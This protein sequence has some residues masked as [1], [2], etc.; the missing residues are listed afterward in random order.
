MSALQ[1]KFQYLWEDLQSFPMIFQNEKIC[2][3]TREK[4]VR[5]VF[6][7]CHIF[8]ISRI[9]NKRSSDQISVGNEYDLNLNYKY[10][11]ISVCKGGCQNRKKPCKD[12]LFR[13]IW[14]YQWGLTFLSREK[15]VC[16]Y[17]VFWTSLPSLINPIES[18][19]LRV[20]ISPACL[21]GVGGDL[22]PI[23]ATLGPGPCRT[24]ELWSFST[25]SS[26]STN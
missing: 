1:W 4:V 15:I 3:K 17:F 7:K 6:Q 8:L 2:I 24:L 23:S 26:F 22:I 18:E 9:N 11:D 13:I 5:L 10:G 12:H 25:N 20:A 21:V 14:P 16:I 19:K